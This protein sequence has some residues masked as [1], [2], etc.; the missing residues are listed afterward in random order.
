M[1]SNDTEVEFWGNIAV[2]SAFHARGSCIP[3]GN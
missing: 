3:S 1:P 2:G